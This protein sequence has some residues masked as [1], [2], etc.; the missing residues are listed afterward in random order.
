MIYITE[1]QDAA[2]RTNA[3]DVMI[4]MTFILTYQPKF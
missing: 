3:S 1:L 2:S 4:N